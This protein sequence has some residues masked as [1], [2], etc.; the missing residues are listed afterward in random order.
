MVHSI[1]MRQYINLME[2]GQVDRDKIAQ[3]FVQNF[4]RTGGFN[5]RDDGKVDVHGSVT[6][7][8]HMSRFPVAFGRIGGDFNC[9]KCGLETLEGGPE[10]VER[11]MIVEDNLL[12]SLQGCPTSIRDGFY[13]DTNQLQDL[14]GAPESVAKTFSCED[15]PLTSLEGLPKASRHRIGYSENLGLLRLVGVNV[16]RLY[17]VP[18]D[19]ATAVQDIIQ[20]HC[21]V[22]PDLRRRMLACQ[23]DLIDAGFAGNARM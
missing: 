7:E 2:A 8:G 1:K 17:G 16:V 23:K 4:G 19:T 18:Q 21:G 15:N 22:G 9:M 5:V 3:I 20:K 13:C 14:K 6:A 12:I 11:N 10:T